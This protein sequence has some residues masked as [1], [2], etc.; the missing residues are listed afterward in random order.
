[1]RNFRTAGVCAIAC[2]A[3][4]LLAPA[5]G[6]SAEGWDWMLA[7]YG[8]GIN[9]ELDFYANGN[10]LI[11]A[12]LDI[13]DILDKLD[14]VVQVHAE[15]RKDALGFFID[16]SFLNLGDTI[17]VNGRPVIPD[18]T[19][20]KTDTQLT[21]TEIGGFYRPSAAEYGF[22][23]LAGARI[24]STDI[25]L[26]ITF[27]QPGTSD[28]GSSGTMTDGFAGVRYSAPF[29]DKWFFIV[30]GDVGAGDSDLALNGVLTFGRNFGKAGNKSFM[31]GYR[32]LSIEI[33]DTTDG[34]IDTE[35]DL[36]IGGPQIG[37]A[38]AF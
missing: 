1:M 37:V 9:P 33:D 23:I 31:F 22:D 19:T 24:I 6:A 35:M 13:G 7:P 27:P 20:V 4:T 14:M 36:D 5:R 18:G 17:E 2:A 15:G 26:D 10:E 34:G 16:V 30:R 21:M 11:N 32:Y 38:F 25:D 29:A 8:W 28:V 3:A 12:E